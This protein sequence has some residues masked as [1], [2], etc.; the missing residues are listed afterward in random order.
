MCNPEARQSCGAEQGPGKDVYEEDVTSQPSLQ[1]LLVGGISPSLP[2]WLNKANVAGYGLDY[3]SWQEE[4]GEMMEDTQKVEKKAKA[5][6][7]PNFTHFQIFLQFCWCYRFKAL[8]QLTLVGQHCWNP[9]NLSLPQI[10]RQHSD[11]AHISDQGLLLPPL[12]LLVTLRKVLLVSTLPLTAQSRLW[13]YPCGTQWW[14]RRKKE[15]SNY[16]LLLNFHGFCFNCW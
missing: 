14:S 13:G 6:Q 12:D 2:M 8:S 3:F 11:K 5:E 15:A 10:W 4:K 9:G 7:E 1:D 16:S